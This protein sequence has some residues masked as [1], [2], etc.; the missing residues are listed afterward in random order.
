V[1]AGSLLLAAALLS[2][3]PAAARVVLFGIDG[4]GWPLID[5]GL[6]AGELPGFASLVARGATAELETVEPVASP[7]VWTSIATG[8]SPDAHGVTDFFRNRTHIRVPTAFERL[9]KRG[10]RVGLYD[11]L[12]TWP[13]RTLPG[14]F[15]IPGWLRRD[16]RVTPPDV[17]ARAGLAPYAYSMDGVRTQAA[18][19]EN[20]RR[21]LREKP[22]RMNRLAEAFAL[23][24]GAVVFYSVDATGH[25]FWRAA[26]PEEFDEP[27]RPADEPF[28]G[29]IHETLRGVDAALAEVA[30]QLRP[31]DTIVV[32][33]D[34]GF[35]ARD[36]SERVWSTHLAEELPAA[37]LDP[38]RDGFVLEG[39]FF[40]ATFRVLPGPFAGREA[41]LERIVALLRS[42]R[43]PDGEPLFSVD[44]LDA[45]PRPAG[46]ERPWLDRLRQWGVRLLLDLAF[47]V[48]LDRPAH[49]Y[50]IARPDDAVLFALWPGGTVRLGERTLGVAELFH[51]DDFSG[52]HHPLGIFLAAGGPVGHV[53]ERGRVSVLD[54][55]PLLFHLCGSP[56]PDDLEGRVPEWLFAAPAAR[57]VR[58][59]PAAELPGL[60]PEAAGA[61]AD[62]AA[63]IER[64]R[65]LG[66]VR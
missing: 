3:E 51:V 36:E 60:P 14:G 56:V 66:Y 34:H 31:E 2:A 20:A 4:G 26:F 13:A 40:A 21:E 53:P 27:S 43:S 62:D 9:A 10:L 8:R 46:A 16:D 18:F 45:A 65:A 17:F 19:A 5:A 61:D 57:P 50:V 30:G 58:I 1:R 23:D 41:T 15:V 39:E 47:D 12:V 6:A 29:V 35:E 64:L 37:G 33:S 28:R 63:L 25:R 52:G 44:V 54:V 24:L 32:V 11:Y 59:V 7:T 38:G 22:G 55:A 49:A 48:K 42:A